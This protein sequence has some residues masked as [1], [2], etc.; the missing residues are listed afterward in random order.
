MRVLT[1]VVERRMDDVCVDV[2]GVSG[3]ESVL[4]L[5]DPLLDAP[6]LDDDHL[7]LVDMLVERVTSTG[8]EHDVDRDRVCT[9]HSGSATPVD[10]PQSNSSCLRSL[11]STNRLIAASFFFVGRWRGQTPCK[12]TRDRS[13]SVTLLIRVWP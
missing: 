4:L 9:R 8:R 6:R 11:A 3:L 12:H 5:F 7:F 10:G 1:G 2:D 13:S